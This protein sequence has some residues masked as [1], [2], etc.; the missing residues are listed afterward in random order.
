ML[1]AGWE[2]SSVAC[3]VPGVTSSVEWCDAS[4][5]CDG[6]GRFCGVFSHFVPTALDHGS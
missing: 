4:G 6:G 1:E 2:A 5:S 3:Q